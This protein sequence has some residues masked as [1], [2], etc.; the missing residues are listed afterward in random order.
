MACALNIPNAAVK[1]FTKWDV[2]NKEMV[3]GIILGQKWTFQS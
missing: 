1:Q 2:N 3:F